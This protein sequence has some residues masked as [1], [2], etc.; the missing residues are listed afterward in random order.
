[1]SPHSLLLTVQ[2]LQLLCCC[3]LPSTYEHE[4]SRIDPWNLPVLPSNPPPPQLGNSTFGD[5]LIP[6]HLWIAVRELEAEL[7]YQLPPLFKRNPGWTVHIESNTMKDTFMNKTFA[8]TSLLWAYHMISPIAGAAKAD[9]WRYAVLWTYGGAYIDDD[10]DMMTPLDKV[11]LPTDSLIVA[12]EKNG[13]NA[14]RCYIPRYHLSDYSAF[15]NG[16]VEVFHGKILLNWAIMS[17]PRHALLESLMKNAVEVIKHEYFQDSVLR[18]LN[19]AHRWEVIMCSTGPSMLS[20]TA[21]ELIMTNNSA[22]LRSHGLRLANVDFRDYGGKFKAFHAPVRND[23]KHYMNIMAKVKGH[24]MLLKEYLP[25]PG[26]SEENLKSWQ[27]QCL[28]GQNGK[29][30][31]VIDQGKKRLIPNYDTLEGLN[32]TLADVIVISDHRI[33]MIPTGEN[34]PNMRST[35]PGRL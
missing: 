21:R 34:M 16:Y 25:E 3:L 35:K 18:T 22:F 19:A 17:M 31:Y 7:N 2:L 33:E 6:R 28:Q 14:N 12:F 32:F 1:M 5:K 29:R 30:I 8:G 24:K 27:G 26:I 13:F 9:L 23:P 4:T 10:S 20:A 15:K 11:I